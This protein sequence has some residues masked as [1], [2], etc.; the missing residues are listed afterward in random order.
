MPDDK[1]YT[2]FKSSRDGP[3][4]LTD[5]SAK[6]LFEAKLKARLQY[7]EDEMYIVDNTAFKKVNGGGCRLLTH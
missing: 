6:S 5:I 3:K 4:F 2:L 1:A 7:K